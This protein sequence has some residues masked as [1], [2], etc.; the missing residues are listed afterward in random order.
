M[1]LTPTILRA[2]IS[3]VFALYGAS[4]FA[5]QA[6][7]ADFAHD[8]VDLESLS[9]IDFAPTK[10][11]SSYER[12]GGN[13]D[14]I[15]LSRIKDSVYTI[16]ELEGPGVI[17]R[18][19]AGK[20]G[21]YLRVYIDGDPKPVIDMPCEEFFSGAHQPFVRPLVGPMGGSNYSYFPIPYAKSVR[22]ET[23]ALEAPGKK[24]SGP[25]AR[26]VRYGLY[27]QVTYQTFPKG[28]KVRSLKLPLSAAART[29]WQHVLEAWRNPGR[30]PKTVEGKPVSVTKKLRV[31]PGETATLAELTGAGI[32]DSFHLKIGPADTG[33]LRSTL[34]KMRWDKDRRD[35]VDCPVGDFFGN[36]FSRVPYRSLLMGLTDEGYYSYFSMAFSSQALLR[37]V[38]E[39]P[40]RE[41]EVDCT[42]VYRKTGGM[43]DNVGHF[44]A[45]WRREEVTAV[46]MT[47]H[48]KT[49]DYNYRILDIRGQGRYVGANLNVF[50]RNLVWWGEGDPMIFVDNEVWPPSIHGTGTEEYFN[51][52]W[53][54][55][56]YI[57]AV[58][59][60][61]DRKQQ[62][63]IP[64][65][66]VLL[67]GIAY[68]GNCYG[69]N[70]VFSFHLADSVPFRERILVTV[71]HGMANDLTNDYASTAYWYAR[72]GG[73]DFFVMRPAN[74]RAVLPPEQW[75]D[76]RVETQKRRS[77]ATGPAR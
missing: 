27:Y 25:F 37:I 77:V 34:L 71:E 56:Q 39:D 57:R 44:H 11:E 33:L 59:A 36:G 22:I 35:A 3:I 21:G 13:Q 63:V 52:G 58:G 12:T 9:H 5:Q 42:I 70:A 29:E 65:S 60:D 32:I 75:A 8:L 55:H 1:S 76:H 6:D 49:G 23:T 74:E 28:T 26:F 48:N 15:L 14:G 54:F 2:A 20:P 72:P 73:R 38:N 50:N 45:K 24:P 66:G 43:P 64:V 67:P 4:L 53:G 68:P 47:S 10:M 30:D 46:N 51:D 40:D 61:P 18:F 69:G 41:V 31:A 17:R 7:F 19:F 16:A 62:N